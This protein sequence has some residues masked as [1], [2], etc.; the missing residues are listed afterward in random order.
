MRRT[1]ATAAAIGSGLIGLALLSAAAEQPADNPPV[2]DS[3][4]ALLE[5]IVDI[6][7]EQ[8]RES[9]VGEPLSRQE[10]AAR[11]VQLLRDQARLAQAKGDRDSLKADLDEIVSILEEQLAESRALYD[12]GRLSRNE[13]ADI[14]IA[15][16]E[17]R[18]NRV[19][20]LGE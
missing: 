15:S 14:E 16:L 1:H 17:A 5:R 19:K 4:I 2:E 18:L 11:R 13:L 3:E 10:E 12:A 9:T 8:N 20:L 6:R 7:Q